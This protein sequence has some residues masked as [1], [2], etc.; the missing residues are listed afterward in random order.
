MSRLEKKLNI[1]DLGEL[2]YCLKVEFERRREPHTNTMTQRRYI[3]EV[4]KRLNMKECKPIG[5]PFDIYSKLLRFLDKKFE[6]VQAKMEG[7]P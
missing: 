7:N 2:H 6:N 4:L 1:S 3:E 5:I